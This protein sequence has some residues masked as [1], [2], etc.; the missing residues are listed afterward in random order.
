MV[1]SNKKKIYSE[2]IDV[3]LSE[4]SDDEMF[5]VYQ[6]TLSVYQ[7]SGVNPASYIRKPVCLASQQP[8]S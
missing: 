4:L 1:N 2:L 5:K 7:H 8:A 6:Y 3:I